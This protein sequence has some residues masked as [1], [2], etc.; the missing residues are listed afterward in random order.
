MDIPFNLG[1]PG[2]LKPGEQYRNAVRYVLDKPS[3]V[4][5]DLLT[6]LWI[7]VNA[8]YT[9][10]NYLV[11]ASS[12]GWGW[13]MGPS[14][15]KLVQEVDA[16]DNSGPYLDFY[17]GSGAYERFT[18][19]GS[20]NSAT[21]AALYSD[22]YATLAINTD[23]SYTMKFPDLSQMKFAPLSGVTNPGQ[24]TNML[25]LNQ[26]VTTFHYGDTNNPTRV[27]S[28]DDGENRT[29]YFSYGAD[30]QPSQISR[31]VSGTNNPTHYVNFSYLVPGNSNPSTYNPLTQITDSLGN[32][33]YFSYDPNTKLI[34]ARWDTRNNPVNTSTSKPMVAYSYYTSGV[35]SGRLNTEQFD[36]GLLRTYSYLSVMAADGTAGL[37]VGI[38]E[39][40]TVSSPTPATRYSATLYNQFNQPSLSW[41]P[42]TTP[43]DLANYP[44][45]TNPFD[46]APVIE[47]QMQYQDPTNPYL[48][49]QM[50]DPNLVP[51]S[52]VYDN[53]GNT[54][55]MTDAVGYTTKYQYTSTVSP[56]LLTEIDPPLIAA[57]GDGGPTSH[58][59][60]MSYD[61]VGNLSSIQDSTGNTGHDTITFARTNMNS[62][63]VSDGRITSITDRNQNTTNLV[64]TTVSD[65][66]NIGNLK[67]VQFPTNSAMTGLLSFSYDTYDNRLT[68]SDSINTVGYQWDNLQRLLQVTPTIANTLTQWSYQD[69]TTGFSDRLHSMTLPDVAELTSPVVGGSSGG[70]TT[71]LSYDA[72]S[73]L[74]AV[75]SQTASGQNPEQLRVSYAYDSWSNLTQLGRLQLEVPRNYQFLYDE[76]DRMI[77]M[78]DPSMPV[79]YTY[80]T[81]QPYC[82]SYSQQT[83][84]LVT[85][86]YTFDNLCRMA[87]IATG[88]ELD[89]V[90]YDAWGQVLS[91]AHQPTAL[92]G[93]ALFGQNRFTS[94]NEPQTKTFQYD[95][96]GR[97]RV[98]TYQ[99]GKTISYTYDYEGNVLS[100][101]D[102][103]TAVSTNYTYYADYKLETV[104]MT[105]GS[106]SQ[107][108]SYF[109]DAAGRLKN[110]IYPGSTNIVA[111]ISS[112]TS[113]PSANSGWDA[114]G[115]ML[116]LVYMKGSSVLQSFLYTYDQAGNRSQITDSSMPESSTTN[117]AYGYDFFGRLVGTNNGMLSNVYSYDESDNRTQLVQNPGNIYEYA[118][119]PDNELQARY[120]SGSAQAS[121]DQY[122]SDLDGNLLSKTVS[123]TTSNYV[124]NDSNRL[125]NIQSNG[126]VESNSYDA[127]GMRDATD[128]SILYYNSALSP[129]TDN[130]S[131]G[132]ISFIQGHQLLGLQENG[133]Y[134]FYLTDHLGSVRHVV[135]SSGAVKYSFAYTEFGSATGTSYLTQNDPSYLAALCQMMTFA[136]AYGVRNETANTG[137]LLMGQRWYSPDTGRFISQDP[138]GFTGGLNLFSYVGQNPTNYVDPSG[139]DEVYAQFT[140][141]FPGEYHTNIYVVQA[142]GTTVEF[143][144]NPEFRPNTS[145]PTALLDATDIYFGN[146]NWGHLTVQE[147]TKTPAQYEA[148]RKLHPWYPAKNV[149]P[150]TDYVSQYRRYEKRINDLMFP[151]NPIHIPLVYPNEALNSNSAAGTMFF[152]S[153]LGMPDTQES[154]N[155]PGLN[156]IL[157]LGPIQSR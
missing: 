68:V 136:G 99:N 62:S 56:Y 51:R 138:I 88:D 122:S 64:Y 128:P 142:N 156:N 28:I 17:D 75:N 24:I 36:T 6:G 49:T 20:G 155:A 9:A 139:L 101:A 123:G 143:Y 141:P 94:P 85:R 32:S 59:T 76:Q 82:R 65:G 125:V 126:N 152:Y 147:E 12:P 2:K 13:S 146:F 54:T 132:T 30:G 25:D 100:V 11:P 46:S 131:S 10:I 105:S 108:F 103:S 80:N 57:Y 71:Y 53:F 19:T 109:Y 121:G 127:E 92:F 7:P 84:R 42:T 114:N 133:N 151:Y 60:K 52:W 81:Y 39:Q 135:D 63:G 14:Y 41:G 34:A 43:L 16:T 27:T 145:S 144:G 157:N 67:S 102:S 5:C 29:V 72:P 18:I 97:L 116:G 1:A 91:I 111:W 66:T 74:T 149:C 37:L 130:N 117:W 86:A 50:V 3:C 33:Q 4:I 104:T 58:P 45:Q 140:N 134:Y 90:A 26:N 153:G 115:R 148:E 129:L 73:R 106:T 70:R 118:Y 47:W 107:Q 38:E 40:D 69:P 21:F 77:Q 44:T 110:I 137:M 48:M 154:R 78:N 89:S 120:L 113:N 124:F 35:N 31:Q 119:L 96:L 87:S 8:V 150:N 22:N 93:S 83:P 23:Q 112:S 98:I 95:Q 79:R 15:A 61:A 55:Q